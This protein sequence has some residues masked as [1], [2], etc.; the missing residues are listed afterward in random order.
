MYEVIDN[1]IMSTDTE[2]IVIDG[3]ADLMKDP[4]VIE[5]QLKYVIG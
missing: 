1:Y 2:F 5:N 3:I 4:N